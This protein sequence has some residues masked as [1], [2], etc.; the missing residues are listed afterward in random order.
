MSLLFTYIDDEDMITDETVRNRLLYMH[1]TLI[2]LVREVTFPQWYSATELKDLEDA[3]TFFGEECNWLQTLLEEKGECPGEGFNIN[4]FHDFMAIPGYIK[5]NGCLMNGDTSAFESYMKIIKMHDL[6][7]KKSR[8]DDGHRKVFLRAVARGTDDRYQAWKEFKDALASALPD[9]F[10]PEQQASGESEEDS[11][12]EDIS[13][14]KD[15]GTTRSNSR[16]TGCWK[17]TSYTL[18]WGTNGPPLDTCAMFDRNITEI[19]LNNGSLVYYT[20]ELITHRDP[21][22]LQVENRFIMPGHCVQLRDG[23]YGQVVLPLVPSAPSRKVQSPEALHRNEEEGDE[24]EVEEDAKLAE[25]CTNLVLLAMFD[26]VDKAV[27]N[28]NHPVV[29]M[30]YLERCSLSYFPIADI[31]R[32][33]HIVPI[34]RPRP[35]NSPAV[36]YAQR[37]LCNCFVFKIRRGP[38]RPP[39]CLSCPYGCP[40]TGELMPADRGDIVTCKK[41]RRGYKWL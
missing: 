31:A 15:E 9:D 14:A 13:H 2:G 3:F 24:T 21:T 10:V 19:D 34:F 32:R 26:F 18:R 22:T 11:D 16:K 25:A 41:C 17:D 30:P 39:V 38:E 12:T 37:F 23:T 6:V 29:P 7:T 20:R 5:K 27:H 4:K 35:D 33:V 36:Q 1:Y 28:G 8:H 40:G